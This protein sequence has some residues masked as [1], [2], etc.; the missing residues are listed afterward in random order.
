MRITELAFNDGERYPILLT[1]DGQPFWFP[2]LFITTQVRNNSKAPNTLRANLNVIR[3]LLLWCEENQV[4]LIARFQKKDFLNENE[5]ESLTRYLQLKEE[6]RTEKVSSLIPRNKEAIRA[7]IRRTESVSN[8]TLYIRLSYA[9][10]Y[11]EW[12]ANRFLQHDSY[13]VIT[14]VRELI[15]HMG[16]LLRM[17]RPVRSASPR[18]QK[19][20][21]TQEQIDELLT[22]I[23]PGHERNPFVEEVQQRNYLIVVLLYE[24]GMRQG[25][26]LAIRVPDLDFSRNE[27]V[28]ARRHDNPD[29][30]RTIQPVVKTNDRRLPVN[31]KLIESIYNYVLST[32][33]PIKQARKHD[34][35]FVVHKNGPY[36][37]SPLSI[38]GLNKLFK[39]L[40]DASPVLLA[41]LSPHILRHTWNDRFSAL[42]D[43]RGMDEATE[44]KLRS[45]QMGWR[46][47]SG[48]AAT[49]TRR[50]T[51]QAAMKAALALQGIND[52]EV[53][54]DK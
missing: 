39:Q 26:L 40:Q 14:D 34:F 29:D 37:G 43:E 20:G 50:H 27:L 52:K 24:L 31:T 16:N 32:R 13:A 42:A 12:L 23:Q 25:E 5:V 18:K 49:Y 47:G 45:Y 6:Y 36:L 17:R 10:D 44:E 35:L 48:T 41:E 9:A 38:R 3:L 1:D 19:R 4:D 53:N 11:L 21:L 54:N 7:K 30:P 33:Y 51:E 28:I 22:V 2:S 46:E 15:R 8:Q